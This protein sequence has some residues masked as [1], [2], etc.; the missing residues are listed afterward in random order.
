[1]K[2]YL[3]AIMISFLISALGAAAGQRIYE[4]GTVYIHYSWTTDDQIVRDLEAIAATGINTINPYPSFLLSYGNPEPDFSKTDL[5]LKT[6][7]R[8]GLRVMPTVYWSGLPPDFAAAKWPDRFSPA[9]DA[10]QREARLT[11]ADPEVI[12]LI[13]YYAK[14]NVLHFKDSPCVIAYNIWDEPHM[15]GFSQS[16]GG[17]RGGRDE[18]HFSHWFEKWGLEKYGSP[19]AWHAQW[20]D[21]LLNQE[22]Q[23]FDRPPILL[24]RD[25]THPATFERAGK[26]PRRGTSHSDS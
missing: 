13:D 26:I 23:G 16:A 19:G 21:V 1:M 12:D 10:D 14:A 22:Y 17:G 24:V 5:I 2:R 25:R 6:A 11:L 8:L 20:N 4:V 15:S 18:A 3:A 9:L 7:S